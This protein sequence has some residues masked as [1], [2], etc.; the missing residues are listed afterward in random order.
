M[1]YYEIG[2][3]IWGS[4]FAVPTDIVDKYLKI[5]GGVSIKVLLW[6][7]R[8]N[9]Q[10]QFISAQDIATALHMSTVDVKEG[11]DFWY[12]VGIIKKSM[13]NAEQTYRIE[14][15]PPQQPIQQT[16]AVVQNSPFTQ[17]NVRENKTTPT[18]ENLSPATPVQEK[19][20]MENSNPTTA[21]PVVKTT[22]MPTTAEIAQ[23]KQKDSNFSSLLKEAE[24]ILARPL[25]H[26]DSS[27]LLLMHD[28]DGLPYEI[29]NMILFFASEQ[30]KLKMKYIES[31][32]HEW[33]AE[34]IDSIEKAEEKMSRTSNSYKVWRR[35]APLFGL[36]SNNDV[37]KYQADMAECW[38]NQWGYS[39]EMLKNAYEICVNTKGMFNL[40]YLNGIL[41]NW[42]NQ[43]ILTEKDLTDSNQS[44]DD[45]KGENKKFKN[46][47]ASNYAGETTSKASYDINILGGV[48][49]ID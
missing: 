46:K 35:I 47:K 45:T 28:Y 2:A 10:K 48:G 23:R 5:A 36:N 3:G 1:E 27:I 14:T 40:S 39:D 31:L 37:S 25:T 26:S 19:P 20:K 8:N 16:F 22:V 11:M 34:G 18:Q 38:V 12:D 32:G 4:V 6:L 17:T 9:S 42:Y 21:L 13:S 7:L 43:G 24:K 33:G 29:I 44:F 41:R 49:L 15:V 30:N